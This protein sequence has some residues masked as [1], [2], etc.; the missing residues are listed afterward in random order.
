MDSW[1]V[2]I[3]GGLLVLIPWL[4]GVSDEQVKYKRNRMIADEYEKRYKDNDKDKQ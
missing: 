1:I 4:F 3:F 2:F